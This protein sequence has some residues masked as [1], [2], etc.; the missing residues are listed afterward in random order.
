TKIG[1]QD[2]H[3]SGLPR[4]RQRRKGMLARAQGGRD[5]F[6]QLP[7]PLRLFPDAFQFPSNRGSCY[8]V[9]IVFSIESWESGTLF[10]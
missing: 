7:A 6:A 5:S 10:P 9:L 4:L 3:G 2:N 8:P 1:E